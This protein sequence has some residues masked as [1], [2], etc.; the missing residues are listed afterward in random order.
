MID[1]YFKD[2]PMDQLD[3]TPFAF[4][5]YNAGP[6]RIG[7]LRRETKKRGLDPHVWFGDVEQIASERIGWETVTYVSNIHKHYVAYRLITAEHGR[8]EVDRAAIK[9]RRV[10]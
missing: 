10:K 7:Q 8:R 3:K 6:A 4:A 9:P 1:R 5:A 2:E